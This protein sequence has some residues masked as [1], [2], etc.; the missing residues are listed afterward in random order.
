HRSDR[1]KCWD[2]RDAYF[3]CL[4]NHNIEPTRLVE[5]KEIIKEGKPVCTKEH[6]EME[7]NCIASWVDY[8]KQKHAA[9]YQ[10]QM[11]IAELERQG[12]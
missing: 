3:A 10:R 8:F 2:K 12:A 1:K 7:E 5:T 6:K 11:A 4:A 9:D